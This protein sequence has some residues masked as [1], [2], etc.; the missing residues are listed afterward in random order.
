MDSVTGVRSGRSR[1][2]SV[3]P[4]ST[5]SDANDVT[6]LLF[7]RELREKQHV[8]DILFLVDDAYH[9]KNA[10]NRIG[11]RFQVCHQGNWN[12]VERVFRE[13]K[14]RTSSFTLL[15]GVPTV[16]CHPT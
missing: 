3:P 9:L 10:L 4:Y 13:V 2:E 16:L 1:Y 5:I 12:A 11:R 7:L 8:S 14:R 15:F 6:H